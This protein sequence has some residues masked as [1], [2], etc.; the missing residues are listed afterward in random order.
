MKQLVLIS[1][2]K[3]AEELKKST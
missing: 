2:G 1:H 3:F